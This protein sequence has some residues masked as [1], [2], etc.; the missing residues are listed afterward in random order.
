MKK[1]ILKL[2]DAQKLTKKEQKEIY[3]GIFR[4]S[5]QG[6]GNLCNSNSD[7]SN[8]QNCNFKLAPI[9]DPTLKTCNCL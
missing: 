2:K 7:C 5:T 6:Q 9:W 4:C 3:G 1:S 8:G